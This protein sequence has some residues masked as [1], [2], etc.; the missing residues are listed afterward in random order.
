MKP[1]HSKNAELIALKAI[2][3]IKSGYH[4]R[5]S[6]ATRLFKAE[7]R[8]LKAEDIKN[9]QIGDIKGYI[10]FDTKKNSK[11]YLLRKDDLLFQSKGTNNFSFHVKEGI[12]NTVISSSFYIIRI[13]DSSISSQFL[14][15]WINTEDVQ[16]ILK[17]NASGSYIPFISKKV[18]EEILIPMV[19][20][21]IQNKIIRI[22]ETWEKEKALLIKYKKTKERLMSN[23]FLQALDILREEK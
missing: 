16:K 15:W 3:D 6:Q 20:M 1:A 18:L 17:K 11:R 5:G 2:A 4:S 21:D 23:H 19:P 7:H 8:F 13:K 9:N 14:S 10:D 22:N 12:S